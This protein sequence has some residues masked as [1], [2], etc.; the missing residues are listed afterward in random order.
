MGKIWSKYHQS[1]HRWLLS[2]TEQFDLSFSLPNQDVNL[3]P[4]LLDDEEKLDVSMVHL[5]LYDNN[6]YIRI[7]KYV[8]NLS[9]E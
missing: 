2:L 6:P 3:V 9:I 4:C 7:Y 8:F 5:Y 1:I